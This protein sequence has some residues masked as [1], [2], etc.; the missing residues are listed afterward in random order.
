VHLVDLGCIATSHGPMTRCQ[1]IDLMAEGVS[2]YIMDE[3]KLPI[4]VCEWLVNWCIT[5]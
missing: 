4:Y 3:C 1:V 2:E 5:P